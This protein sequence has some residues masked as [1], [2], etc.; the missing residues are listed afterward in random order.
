MRILVYG[1][2]GSGKTTLAKRIATGL[3]LPLFLVD[4]MMWMPGWVQRPKA[5]QE[6][7]MAEAIASPEWVLDSAYGWAVAST[8]ERA[9]L[10]VALDYPQWFV[11]GR[12]VARSLSRAITKE[13]CCNGN[14]E[15]FRKLYSWDSIVIWQFKSFGSKRQRIRQWAKERP[16]GTIIVHRKPAETEAWLRDFLATNR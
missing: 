7:L 3:G 1:V 2:T 13:P 15:S 10:V 14:T 6:A 12:L 9:D 4:D 8:L 11:L 16:A 5:E